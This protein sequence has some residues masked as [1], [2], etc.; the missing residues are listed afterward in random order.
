MAPGIPGI[1]RGAT[2]APGAVTVEPA[3]S[4]TAMFRFFLRALGIMILAA[5][6]VCLVYDGA[7]SV[8]NNGLRVTALDGLPF[9]SLAKP[10]ATLK[11]TVEG[12]APWLWQAI[13]LPLSVAPAALIGLVLGIVLVWLGRPRREP[14]LY[15]G[16]V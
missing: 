6:F 15:P 14:A 2:F 8:A 5:G 13:L 4:A 11:T 12:V 16:P 10:L 7:R 1:R 3:G 9:T